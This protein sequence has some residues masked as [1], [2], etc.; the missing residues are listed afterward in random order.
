MVLFYTRFL[1]T[2]ATKNE[3]FERKVT[4]DIILIDLFN[5]SFVSKKDIEKV[6][7]RQINN[8]VTGTVI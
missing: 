3:R 6:V 8:I 7:A 4:G 1:Y 2:E 5:G